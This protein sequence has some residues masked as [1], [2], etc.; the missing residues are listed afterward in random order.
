MRFIGICIL[1]AVTLATP[2]R[3][4][5]NLK[6]T[7]TREDGSIAFL[8]ELKDKACFSIYFSH[9]VAKSTVEEWFCRKDQDLFLEKT[10]YHDFGAGLPHDVDSG[11][12]MRVEDGKI[13]LDGF[14]KK[15]PHFTVRVGRIANHTLSIEE[16]GK[17]K[18]YP[19]TLFAPPGKPLSFALTHKSLKGTADE[20]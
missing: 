20:P 16:C 6:L 15:L 8:C 1:F 4:D 3:S 19:L 17:Q 5:D 2:C 14:H 10:V 7:V 9:S 11:Q 13:V 18:K 12:S